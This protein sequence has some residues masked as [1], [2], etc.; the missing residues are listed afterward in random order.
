MRGYKNNNRSYG[1]VNF[2]LNFNLKGRFNPKFNLKIRCFLRLKQERVSQ[3]AA[4]TQIGNA[5]YFAA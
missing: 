2:N 1:G 3:N 4:N 5:H